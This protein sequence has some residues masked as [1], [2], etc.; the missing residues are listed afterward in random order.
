MS[1][2]S[3]DFVYA[4]LAFDDRPGGNVFCADVRGRMNYTYFGDIDTFDATLSFRSRR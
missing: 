3:P 2:G 1:S 4:I